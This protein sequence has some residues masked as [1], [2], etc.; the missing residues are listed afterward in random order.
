[1]IIMNGDAYDIEISLNDDTGDPISSAQ[2]EKLEI[3]LGSI[4]KTFPDEVTFSEGVFHFPLSQQETMSMHG[5]QHFQM[6]AKFHDGSVVGVK[7]D[8]VRMA[9]SDSG[10]IL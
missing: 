6:R 8:P 10:V 4:R 2:L 1:M 7:L 9:P 3:Q 5:T